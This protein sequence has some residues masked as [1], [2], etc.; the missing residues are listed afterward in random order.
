MKDSLLVYGRKG[1]QPQRAPRDGERAERE[2][3]LSLSG[4]VWTLCCALQAGRGSRL[5]SVGSAVALALLRAPRAAAPSALTAERKRGLPVT[6][7]TRDYE[8][9]H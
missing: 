5:S 8:A 7:F 1:C 3:G 9:L 4:P 6:L 2:S